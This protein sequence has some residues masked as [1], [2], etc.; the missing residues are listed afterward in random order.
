MGF[1]E[2]IG[3]LCLY[4]AALGLPLFYIGYRIGQDDYKK[5]E[6]SK[7]EQRIE[8]CTRIVTTRLDS[9]AEKITETLDRYE[10]EQNEH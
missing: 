9:L 10:G 1:T 8:Q 3:K 2:N 5:F 7:L 4:T 6:E